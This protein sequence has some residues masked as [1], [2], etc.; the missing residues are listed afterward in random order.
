MLH[1]QDLHKIM[2]AKTA[3]KDKRKTHDVP[4]RMGSIA[5][6]ACWEMESHLHTET[7]T[8]MEHFL[9]GCGSSQGAPLGLPM[10]H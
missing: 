7:S 2:P 10:F 6:G 8:H 5:M 9:Q 1:V 4:S 3:R